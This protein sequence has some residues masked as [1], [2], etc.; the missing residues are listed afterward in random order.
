MRTH[1]VEG[2]HVLDYVSAQIGQRV[3]IV[4]RQFL[5]LHTG[6][7]RFRDGIVQWCSRI[8]IRLRDSKLTKMPPKLERSILNALIGME[9]QS[10]RMLAFST[11]SKAI[12]FLAYKSMIAP[13]EQ[14]TSFTYTCVIS[15]TQI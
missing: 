15:L 4:V 9:G 13:M 14:R 2:I 8:G 6:E 12:T 5:T 11:I 10:N 7:E 3:V 1:I